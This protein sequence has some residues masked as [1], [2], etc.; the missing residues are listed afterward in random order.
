MVLVAIGTE[1]GGSR[2][3]QELLLYTYSTSVVSP[4]LMSARASFSELYEYILSRALVRFC[5]SCPPVPGAPSQ[6]PALAHRARSAREWDAQ[7][8]AP[9]S[10][11][12][13]PC[14]S[15]PLVPRC[16]ERVRAAAAA[17]AAQPSSR[18]AAPQQ[19]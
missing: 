1:H 4:F 9:W 14:R 13:A 10:A 2:L 7:P 17:A 19:I 18:L 15:A 5:R 11:C 6:L 12:E 3:L 16:S 8:A